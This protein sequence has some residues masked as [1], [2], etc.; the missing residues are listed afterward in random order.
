M[1][2]LKE[3][4]MWAQGEEGTWKPRKRKGREIKGSMAGGHRA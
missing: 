1:G 4:A 2:V 3:R